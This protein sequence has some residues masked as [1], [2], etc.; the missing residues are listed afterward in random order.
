MRTSIIPLLSLAILLLFSPITIC[1]PCNPCLDSQNNEILPL[2]GF[3]DEK[4][5][6]QSTGD[7]A[8][9]DIAAG[10][11]PMGPPTAAIV[12]VWSDDTSDPPAVNPTGDHEV[13]MAVSTDEGCTFTKAQLTFNDLPDRTPAVSFNVMV[14][15]ANVAFISNNTDV[16]NIQVT[17]VSS[18]PVPQIPVK[19]N[20]SVRPI[21]PQNLDITFSPGQ[22]QDVYAAWDAEVS[23]GPIGRRHVFFK[24]NRLGG[25]PGAWEGS[26]GG[27]DETDLTNF[28]PFDMTNSTQ[29]SISS[30]TFTR[31]PGST[32]VTVLFSNDGPCNRADSCIMFYRSHDSGTVFSGDPFTGSGPPI[33]ISDIDRDLVQAGYPANDASDSGFG[34]PEVWYPGLW[35]GGAGSADVY[36]DAQAEDLTSYPAI[37]NDPPP[38]DVLISQS[39]ITALAPALSVFSPMPGSLQGAPFLAF[40]PTDPNGTTSTEIYYTRGH[41]LHAPGADKID[42]PCVN[43]PYRLTGEYPVRSEGIADSVA[44]DETMLDVFVAFRDTRDNG[45][46]EIYFKRSDQ[47]QP[48]Q[49]FDVAPGVLDC[50]QV[51]FRL[52]WSEWDCDIDHYRV[53]YDLDGGPDYD[54]VIDN[55][56]DTFVEIDGLLPQTTYY[57]IVIPVDQACNEGFRSDE[58][59]IETNDCPI[60][61]V[62]DHMTW[63]DDCPAGAGDNNGN[64]EPGEQIINLELWVANLKSQAAT[65]CTGTLT[66]STAGVSVAAPGTSTYQTIGLSPPPVVNDALFTLNLDISDFIC[67][68]TIDLDLELAC[69]QD[70]F[71]IPFKI[72]TQTT[73]C[74]PCVQAQCPDLPGETQALKAVKN[75]VD[76]DFSW[77]EDLRAID[78]YNIWYV[79]QKMDIPF[80]DMN[81]QPPAQP[82]PGCCLPFPSL[83]IACSHSGAISEPDPV[84]F[85]QVKGYCV[86]EEGP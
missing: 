69:D 34:D 35:I 55:I 58:G 7:S 61:L 60:V 43:A 63:E 24:R 81:N 62:A 25:A 28:A 9:P 10:G 72:P 1:G 39:P 44:S 26:T 67:G 51:G 66:S 75:G 29:P 73:P 83:A 38:T 2:L 47:Q 20:T 71:S 53:E 18:A 52:D 68:T 30:D 85:Y 4:N 54:F 37:W 70:V 79:L 40:W 19:L 14:D 48:R 80:A 76:I 23:T 33:P 21:N 42:L 86:D 49:L 59:S 6:S 77:Q 50:P 12:I 31:N 17:S 64:P 36:M 46:S 41:V 78:G 3:W 74:E 82:V 8:E 27:P 13:W 22:F 32:S 15:I 57:F 45:D 16:I 65:G 11:T 5:I 84:H 56:K